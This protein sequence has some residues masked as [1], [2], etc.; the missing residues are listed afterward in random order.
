MKFKS[1]LLLITTFCIALGT[2]AQYYYSR[3]YNYY[4]ALDRHDNLSYYPK[5]KERKQIYSEREANKVKSSQKVKLN[6][7]Q[8]T[9]Y[10][11]NIVYNSKGRVIASEKV[12]KKGRKYQFTA[13]YSNDTLLSRYEIK[14][15]KKIR[16]VTFEYNE[17]GKLI[18][19]IHFKNGEKHY[20]IKKS[21]EG[22]QTHLLH[23]KNGE[24]YYESD[25]TYKGKQLL[26]SISIDYSKRKPRSYKTVNTINEEGKV[27][28]TAYYQNDELKRTWE[29]DCSEK[30]VEVKPKKSEEGVPLSTTCSWKEE[31]S[32]GSYIN[33]YRTLNGKR[34]N[35]NE[36]H[37]NK[38]SVLV[39]RKTYDGKDRLKFESTNYENHNVYLRYKKN[40]KVKSY[41]SETSDPEV[42][43]ISTTQVYYG[44]G[45]SHISSQKS[46][47]E[48]GLLVEIKGSSNGK[49]RQSVITYE[50]F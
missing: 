38:D 47:N 45:K 34:I 49:Q 14:R 27:I 42:G 2:Q 36:N 13:S 22:G 20:E 24:K 33:Y 18:H 26:E 19:L 3:E 16:V 30:G 39:K 17:E 44:L 25:K 12:D 10:T 7:K 6:H 35:L 41:S 29:Y 48:Q 43:V 11:T 50:Y 32:D 9:V 5:D 23:L 28:K 1:T 8:D 15:D 37:Y 31:S 21:Y 4:Y 46:Y 40:G